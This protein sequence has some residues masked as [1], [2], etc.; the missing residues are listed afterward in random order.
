MENSTN[1]QHDADR[2]ETIVGT[3]E[4]IQ[5]NGN[6][7]V[8][9]TAEGETVEQATLDLEEA[10]RLL[11]DLNWNDNEQQRTIFTF[12]DDDESRED[13]DRISRPEDATARSNLENADSD[14]SENV[15]N[16][17]PGAVLAMPLDMLAKWNAEMESCFVE[18][19]YEESET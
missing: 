11:N 13:E 2:A 19:H 18:E 6:N 5:N 9:D 7:G 12:N 3:L 17:K 14:E 8:V 16:S 1:P 4:S 10:L 15:S